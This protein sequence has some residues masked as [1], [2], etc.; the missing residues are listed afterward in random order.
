MAAALHHY[1]IT[2]VPSTPGLRGTSERNQTNESPSGTRETSSPGLGNISC[3]KALENYSHPLGKVQ[4]KYSDFDFGHVWT[5]HRK[6]GEN[7]SY[8]EGFG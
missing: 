6:R 4:S 2:S 1:L 3:A 8:D 7:L 5:L